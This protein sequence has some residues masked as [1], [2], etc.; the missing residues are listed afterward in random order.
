MLFR[1]WLQLGSDK[2]RAHRSQLLLSPIQISTAS[3]PT[4]PRVQGKSSVGGPLL[5]Q[6]ELV[7]STMADGSGPSFLPRIASVRAD[8]RWAVVPGVAELFHRSGGSGRRTV[9]AMQSLHVACVT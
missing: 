1:F 7:G 9:S 2:R 3:Y 4:Y 5:A 8:Q 6:S